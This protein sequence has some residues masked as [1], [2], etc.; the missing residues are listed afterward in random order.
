[1][2]RSRNHFT[3]FKPHSLHKQLILKT[4]FGA[5]MTSLAARMAGE[6]VPQ[7]E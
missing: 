1:L 4:Y 3:A 5:T 7:S 6:Q 2:A